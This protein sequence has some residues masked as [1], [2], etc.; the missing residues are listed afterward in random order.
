MFHFKTVTESES[1]L[2]WDYLHHTSINDPDALQMT[3]LSGVEYCLD[4]CLTNTSVPFLCRSVTY[5]DDICYF[6]DVILDEIINSDILEES[7]ASTFIQ[8]YCHG[9]R[10]IDEILSV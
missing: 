4:V 8:Y 6:H 9:K 3:S 1:D 10:R 5:I 2:N 7:P